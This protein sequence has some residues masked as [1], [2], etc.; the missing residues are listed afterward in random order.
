MLYKPE[1]YITRPEALKLFDLL[2]EELDKEDDLNAK[3]VMLVNNIVLLE[4]MKYNLYDDIL[5]R[6]VVELFKNGSQ[7]MFRDNKSVEKI[8]GLVEQ[9]RKLQA[10]LKLTPASKKK[11]VEVIKEKENDEFDNF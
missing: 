1:P 7:E 11:V 8:K 10:E 3:T 5:T 4:Q 2:I 6:G 9:Q